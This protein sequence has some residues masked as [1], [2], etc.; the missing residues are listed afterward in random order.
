MRKSKRLLTKTAAFLLIVGMSVSLGGCA[1]G[2]TKEGEKEA[3]YGKEDTW[4]IYWYLCGS[5][6]ES[7]V[8]AA[9][10]DL[11]EMLQVKLPD[12]VKVII[13]TGG[14]SKWQNEQVKADRIQRY[15]YSG[16]TLQL[17]DETEQA[18]MGDEETLKGFLTYTEKNYQADH[19]ML[20]FWNHGGGSVS[21]VAFDENYASDSLT[22]DEMYQV[23]K[24]VYGEKKP[25]EVVG[26]DTCLMA[27]LDTANA[28]KNYASYMVASEETEPGNGWQYNGWLAKL[29]ADPGMNGEELGKEICDS[30]ANGCKECG[31]DNEITLSVTDLSKTDAVIGALK[32][33]G[34]VVLKKA[35]KDS[36][37]C[38]EFARS[39]IKAE[40]YGGNNDKE[41]YTNMVDLGSLAENAEDLIGDSKTEIE[42]ALSEAVVYKINGKYRAHASGLSVYYSYNG[43]KE[44]AGKYNQI[45]AEDIYSAFVNYSIGA[46]VSPESLNEAGIGEVQEVSGFQG[47]LPISINE[48]DY[49]QL[50]IRPDELD[51][52]QSVAFNLAYMSDDE[53]AIILLGSDNDLEF[54]WENGIFQDNFQGLWG[55]VNGTL[56]YMELVYE[57]E[58][59]N[60]YSVP[61]KL[62]KKECYMSVAYDY[63]EKAYYILG[64]TSGVDNSGQAGKDLTPIKEGDT[65]SFLYYGQSL[66]KEAEIETVESDSFKWKEKYA[67]QD[68]ELPDGKYAF[69]FEVTDVFGK[70]TISDVSYLSYHD[71]E[72]VPEV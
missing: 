50:N 12:N 59:Y 13:Q 40:N 68:M 5:D 21:G 48:E 60:L 24:D 44:A 27:T 32:N 9:T 49:I 57:G 52:V 11:Q 20:L 7:G 62:N 14:A 29:A 72:I 6:L 31:T 39:A 3:D 23:M 58:D 19:K 4:A 63:K 45:A 26:F 66:E 64:A 25:F 16:E 35:E 47:E 54:D 51:S 22:L 1:D 15:E 37:V 70:K 61:I 38:A 30:F 2:G 42:K 43:D 17:K 65:V 28:F 46:E 10:A 36:S 34:K 33:M 41:G 56:C 18:N 55:S 67:F 69:L 71:G 8:G 53:D